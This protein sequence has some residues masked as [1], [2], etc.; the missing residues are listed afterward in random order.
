MPDYYEPQV[1]LVRDGIT[2]LYRQIP[3]LC[4]FELASMN[5]APFHDPV[6]Q[7]GL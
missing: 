2:P 5:W 3:S 1:T 4:V 7:R 6:A